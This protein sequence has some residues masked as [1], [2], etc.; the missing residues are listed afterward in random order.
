VKNIARADQLCAEFTFRIDQQTDSD[1]FII[2]QMEKNALRGAGYPTF[3]NK[4]LVIVVRFNAKTS[5]T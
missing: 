1:N 5:H 3:S 4:C 2:F